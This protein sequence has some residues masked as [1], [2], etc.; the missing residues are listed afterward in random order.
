MLSL[1]KRRSKRL[2]LEQTQAGIDKQCDD[3]LA[4]YGFP[5]DDEFRAMFGQL[6]QHLPDSED[7][8]D[9]ELMARRIRKA[10]AT[11]FAFYLIQPQR[12]PKEKEVEAVVVEEATI[13]STQG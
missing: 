9:P 6:I 1:L 2:P 5:L 8:Y 13:A 4:K 3:F 11:R 10:V 12:R 7:D